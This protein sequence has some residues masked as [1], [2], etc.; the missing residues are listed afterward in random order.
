MTAQGS[1]AIRIGMDVGGT[2][3]EGVAVD[4]EGAILA[5]LRRPTEWGPEA[6]IAG[7]V[8]TTR[9]LVAEAGFAASDIHSVGVGVPGLV[10]A[11]G[12]RVLHAVNLG[13]ESLD[14]A[15]LAG[16][17]IGAPIF[18]ENDVKAA[19]LGAASLRDETAPMAYLNLGTGVAAGIVIDGRLWRGARGIAGE[20]GHI[21]VEPHGRICGCGQRGCIETLCGGGSVGRAWGRGGE[22][23]VLDI[24]DAADAG[25]AEA[26]VLRSG[27][28]RGAA[29]A[30]TVLVLTADVETVVI[31]GGLTA[32]ADRLAPDL[33][34]ALRANAAD[35]PF[36]ASL[37]LDERFE[38]LPSGSPVAPL[39]AALLGIE[40]PSVPPA[41]IAGASAVPLDKE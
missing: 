17:E 35:S 40:R 3:T 4:A 11:A 26:A 1:R 10:D 25:D 20:V 29:S 24:Y 21:P 6:V 13:V 16:P 41:G 38:L 33:R 8:E 7:I 30:V 5:R 2:K 9:A 15:R 36:F 37:H 31:G 19:A 27:I 39:G 14:I 18:V 22:Y 12:G 28:A 32:L 23:P 34:A